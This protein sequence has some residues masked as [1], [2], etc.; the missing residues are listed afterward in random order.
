[1]TYNNAIA[2]IVFNKIWSLLK[3][4]LNVYFTVRFLT[5]EEQGLWFTFGSLA[6]VT[7]LADLGFTTIISQF[8]S[9]EF[10][11][12]TLKEG[13]LHGS[14]QKIE[15][16]FSLVRFSLKVYIVIIFIAIIVLLIIGIIMFAELSVYLAWI[17]YSL[18]SILYL[19]KTLFQSIIIGIDKITI[20]QRTI[21]IEVTIFSIVSWFLMWLGYGIWGLII[22][23]GISIIISFL[24]LAYFTWNFWI[25]IYK[26]QITSHYTWKKEILPL[27]W[28]YSISCISGYF[29]FNLYTPAI[30]KFE[31]A[32]SA[33]QFGLTASLVSFLFSVSGA[34]LE[35]YTPRLAIL[36]SQQEHTK[37]WHLFKKHYLINII[38][39]LLGSIIF[40]GIIYLLNV[41]SFYSERFLSVKI[42]IAYLMLQFVILLI[43]GSAKYPR[44]YKEEPYY[45]M[46]IFQSISI[47]L[48]IFFILPHYHLFSTL[49]IID[50]TYYIFIL[51]IAIR[52][53]YK[54]YFKF[55]KLKI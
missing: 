37:L 7:I 2:W 20:V 47:S 11:N 46:S 31:G 53:L 6:A 5:G 24:F 3:G 51:P 26:T 27:Q 1:M 42:S 39:F 36:A 52:I 8:V 43:T 15:R 55:A 13:Y 44:A 40:L 49:A 45:M 38:F 30:Y 29:I 22:A 48:I 54:Y 25:Q 19:I 9:Y 32:I 35:A 23:Q 17:V 34:G 16:L 41:I 18:I 33:G 28:K 12:L 21:F 50:F 14:Q 4:P 10:A